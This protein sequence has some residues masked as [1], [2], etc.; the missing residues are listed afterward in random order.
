M[1]FTLAAA[2]KEDGPDLKV[3]HAKLGEQAL[4]IDFPSGA[5]NKGG[6]LSAKR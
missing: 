5:L 6:L 4:E 2:R 1:R 3:L